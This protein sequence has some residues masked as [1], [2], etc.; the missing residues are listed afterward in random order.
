MN[1]EELRKDLAIAFLHLREQHDELF[2]LKNEVAAM[3]DLMQGL[4]PTFERMFSARLGEWRNHGRAL[5][6]ETLLKFD[7]VILK[8]RNG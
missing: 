8:L 2:E 5:N 1:E 3:R 4:S 6:A 7:E